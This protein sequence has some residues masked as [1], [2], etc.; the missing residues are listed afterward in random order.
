MSLQRY[1]HEFFEMADECE[2]PRMQI[3]ALTRAIVTYSDG[4]KL[5]Q[6]TADDLNKHNI[7]AVQGQRLTKS[8]RML[9]SQH[10]LL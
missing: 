4:I 9:V 2:C 8:P 5:T 3:N 6:K 7:E 10:Y 1:S